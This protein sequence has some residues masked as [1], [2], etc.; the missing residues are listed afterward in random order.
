MKPLATLPCE[1][2]GSTETTNTLFP[3]FL[4]TNRLSVLLIGGG[5][6]A[7]EK[8]QALLRN[9]PQCHLTIVAIQILDEL[10]AYSAQFPNVTLVERAVE[11]SDLDDVQLVIAAV[12]CRATGLQIRQ[13]AQQR[14]ILVNVADTPDLCDFYLGSI[15][16]KG[17]LK[18]AISTNGQSPTLAK[19]IR[20][21]LNDL[22]P[23]EINETLGRLSAIRSQMQGSLKEKII[24]LNEITRM[25][26][27]KETL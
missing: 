3:V 18:I 25:L 24:R 26:V 27:E 22:I 4:K 15:V 1:N 19:R 13:W 14:G 16:Q 6:V 11:A 9:S 21:L 5:F 7:C 20:E 2:N 8:A 12:N 23:D 10:R 17:N